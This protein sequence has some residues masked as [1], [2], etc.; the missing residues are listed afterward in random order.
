MKRKSRG[1]TLIELLTTVAIVGILTAVALP[2][3]QSYVQ[4]ARLSEAFAGLGGVQLSTEQYWSNN[5][6]YVGFSNANGLPAATANFSYALTVGTVSAYTVTASGLGNM[7]GF[8][9]TIDQAGNR[10]TTAAPTGWVLSGTCWV[11]R[12]SGACTQ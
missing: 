6:T 11:D 12:K 4:R 2:A 3:Y 1:F 9:Y 8:A 10:V 7:A 5:R